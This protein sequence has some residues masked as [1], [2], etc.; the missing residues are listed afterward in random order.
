MPE[1]VT[2][3]VV[4]TPL[5]RPLER[6]RR[7]HDRAA[8]L[9]VPAHV[10]ILYPWLPASVLGREARS[11][12][13]AIASETRAFEVRFGA[14]GRWPGVVYLEPEPAWRFSALIDRVAARFPEYPP[15]AGAIEEV[16]PHLTLVERTGA[17]LDEIA[18]AAAARLPFVRRVRAIEVLVEDGNRRWRP[19]WRL[20]L[21]PAAPTDDPGPGLRP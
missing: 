2:A 3:I 17:P 12:L 1:P 20:P 8:A 9:G 21:A 6:V 11:A 7:R 5:P 16:I 4:R 13:A 14:V 18:A 19:R 15:Y 10:T